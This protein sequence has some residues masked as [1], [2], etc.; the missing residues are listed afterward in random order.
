MTKIKFCGLSRPEDIKA[1]NVLHP[2]YIG[3]VFVPESRRFI[4][5]ERA[6][7]LRKLLQVDT[8]V[9]GVFVNETFET[10]AHLLN[11]G[12]IDLAQLHGNENE[13]YIKKL[14]KDTGKQII[15]TFLINTPE[16]V[17]AASES[18]AEYILLDSGWGTGTV[19]D[20]SLIQNVKRPY[21][22]AGGLYS[23]NVQNAVKTLKPYAVDVSSGI[24]TYGRKDPS[25]MA[26]FIAAVRIRKED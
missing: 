8:K 26:E 2:E 23:G 3:F 19:F 10:V 15:K 14:K 13:E 12:I 22:L 25:K 21:F 11:S 20:W 1:V 9:V 6:A 18:N 16:D 7:E 5:L 24:E 17:N 4:P